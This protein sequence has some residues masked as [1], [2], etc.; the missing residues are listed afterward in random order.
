[1][2]GEVVIPRAGSVE[3]NE[4]IRHLGFWYRFFVLNTTLIGPGLV[5]STCRAQICS[6]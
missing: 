2:A 6:E 1:V 4:P 3:D 5:E